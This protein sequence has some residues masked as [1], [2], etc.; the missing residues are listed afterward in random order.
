MPGTSTG[1][2]RGWEVRRQK[3]GPTGI[4]PHA[5][6][7]RAQ[8]KSVSSTPTPDD[9]AAGYAPKKRGRPKMTHESD[10]NI[11]RDIG[12]LE[13]Y[14]NYLDDTLSGFAVT[15]LSRRNREHRAALRR[16]RAATMKHLAI[17]RAR[18]VERRAPPPLKP[19]GK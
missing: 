1:A 15:G 18:L 8:G 7:A 10:V 4:R 2:K 12:R 3:Y 17:L 14:V 9:R 5:E 11:A 16:E 13:R 19:R 6:R